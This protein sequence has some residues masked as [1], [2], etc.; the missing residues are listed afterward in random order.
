MYP[1]DCS[2][3]LSMEVV[4]LANKHRNNF[5]VGIDLAGFEDA[6]PMEKHKSAFDVS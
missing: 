2:A 3:D 1:M 6:E 5:V 4:E